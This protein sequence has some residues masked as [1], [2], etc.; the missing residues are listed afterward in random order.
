MPLQ[1]FF[2]PVVECNLAKFYSLKEEDWAFLS[3]GRQLELRLTRHRIRQGLKLE[4]QLKGL[5]G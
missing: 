2:C 1:I 4:P 5:K 3:H